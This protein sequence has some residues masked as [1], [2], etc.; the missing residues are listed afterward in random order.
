MFGIV[1]GLIGV[2]YTKIFH[3]TKGIFARIKISRLY[4]PVLGALCAGLTGLISP[5]NAKGIPLIFRAGYTTIT[6]I[7][8]NDVT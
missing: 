5:K 8:E 1:A 6:N 3:F 2:F 7:L 4:I